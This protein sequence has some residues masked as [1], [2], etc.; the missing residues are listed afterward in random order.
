MDVVT[1]AIGASGEHEEATTKADASLE[2]SGSEAPE[3]ATIWPE[4]KGMPGGARD[5]M[6]AT[7]R[8]NETHDTIQR[9]K[10]C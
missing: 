9:R 6:E 1:P 7:R 3:S 2:Q 4:D 8:E 5:E 10:S